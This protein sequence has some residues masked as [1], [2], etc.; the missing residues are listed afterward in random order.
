MPGDSSRLL[1]APGGNGSVEA[2]LHGRAEEWWT[3]VSDEIVDIL[4][5]ALAHLI[6]LCLT[7]LYLIG[8]LDDAPESVVGDERDGGE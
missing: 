8:V 4:A 5:A 2:T 3:T 6:L 7:L 1:A